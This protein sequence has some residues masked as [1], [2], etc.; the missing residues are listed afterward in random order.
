MRRAALVAMSAGLVALG[1]PAT[2]AN[3]EETASELGGF[4]ARAIATPIR[5]EIYESLIPIPTTPQLELNV[6]YTKSIAQ[7]GPAGK[8]RA[9]WLWPGDPV[10]EGLKVFGEQLNLPPQLF[11]NGYTVQVNSEYPSDTTS[12]KDEPLPGTVMRTSADEQTTVAKAGFSTTGDVGDGDGGKQGD[13]GEGDGA[14]GGLPGF[15]SLPGLPSLGGG[16]TAAEDEPT[17]GLG[18]LSAVVTAGGVSSVS[19]TSYGTDTIVASAITRL[20]DLSLLGGVITAE[21]VKVVSRTSSTLTESKNESDVVVGGLAIGGVPFSFTK[22]GAVV[23]GQK[24]EI[25]GL[26]DEPAEALAELGVSFTLPTA[27]G[28]REGGAGEQLVR[29]LQ[30]EIDFAKLRDRFDSGP[31][32]GIIAQL[33]D[34]LAEVKKVLGAATQGKPRIVVVLGDALTETSTVEP[35]VFDPPATEPTDETPAATPGAIDAP[36]G[37]VGGPAAGAPLDAPPLTADPASGEVPTA[38][39]T[40]VP[41]GA[42]LPPLGSVPG[43]LLIGGLVLASALGWWIQ[44]VGGV[45]LGGAAACSHGLASGVPD[46]RKA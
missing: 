15:P 26:P 36:A 18:A 9:S 27:T 22:D 40:L 46:L 17:P 21:S 32:D 24:Q 30:V 3:A 14:G 19:K 45:V 8:G 12:Q 25:P 37:T 23:A 20:G 7:S 10:G 42:G 13:G 33:P 16:V 44:K 1:L 39:A 4:S 5:V 28:T 34:E 41:T 35:I 11:E 6:A 31:V 38:P 29:G 43:A 2:Q